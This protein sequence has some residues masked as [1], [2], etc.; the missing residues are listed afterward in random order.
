MLTAV[1]LDADWLTRRL[2]GRG[3]RRDRL[4]P[5]GADPTAPAS[6]ETSVIRLPIELATR[7]RDVAAEIALAQ[8]A[9]YVCPPETVHVTVCGPTHLA[10]AAA[11]VA[12]LDDLRAVV[13]PLA[14]SRLR[15][16]RIAVGDTSLFAGVEAVGAD[17]VAAR[18]HL[19][20]RWGV[21]G[22]SGPAW[23]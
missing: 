21:P 4:D 11:T 12:A 20:R 17:L 3:L 16:V 9:Q 5:A 1:V 13:E 23:P 19:A 22:R 10:D 18:D 15:V 6:F 14:G 7:L 8:P 2:T